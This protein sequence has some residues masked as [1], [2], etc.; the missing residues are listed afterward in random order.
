[1]LLKSPKGRSSLRSC[2][3]SVPEAKSAFPA[4]LKAGVTAPVNRLE[5]TSHVSYADRDG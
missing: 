1:M 4:T 3:A 2:S 5:N